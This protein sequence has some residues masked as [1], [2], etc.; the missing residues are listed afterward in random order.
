MARAKE[1]CNLVNARGGDAQLAHLPDCG[2]HGNT[3]FVFADTN[4]ERIADMLA[5]LA[6]D[7]APRRPSLTLV[8]ATVPAA[9]LIGI[10]GCLWC[11]G[12]VK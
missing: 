1:F 7:Q 3:H 9:R 5:G 12:G 2:V 4:N 11:M 6:E 8:D 10:L